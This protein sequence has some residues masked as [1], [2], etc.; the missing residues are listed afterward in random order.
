METYDLLY[1]GLIGIITLALMKS[2]RKLF[3]YSEEDKRLKQ[4]GSTAKFRFFSYSWTI[5]I[6]SNTLI[7]WALSQQPA[8][9][10]G[11]Y[12]TILAIIYAAYSIILVVKWPAEVLTISP[13]VLDF[14]IGNSRELDQIKGVTFEDDRLIIYARDYPK[15]TRLLR[16]AHRGNWNDLQTAV[17]E[18]I[19]QNPEIGIKGTLPDQTAS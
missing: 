12:I 18:F 13:T 14:R 2:V 1:I 9:K 19:S 7:F 6:F 4:E 3:T 11:L 8:E 16:K 10:A 15:K 17:Y 5:K